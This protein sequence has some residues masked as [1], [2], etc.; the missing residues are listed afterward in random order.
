[1]MQQEEQQEDQQENELSVA[2]IND[3]LRDAEQRLKASAA[4]QVVAQDKPKNSLL[5]KSTSL[6]L[7]SSPVTSYIKGTAQGTQIDSSRLVS[8]DERK[9]AN[10]V[11]KVEDPVLVK[12]RHEN[13]KK[14]SAGP[15]WF[16]MPRTDVTPELKRDMQLLKMRSVLDPKRFYKKD[17]KK[18]D[19]PEFSQV[20]TIIEGPTEFRSARLTNKERKRTLVEEV[21]AGE[22]TTRRFKSKYNEIQKAKTSGRKDH[23]K[24]IKA[25]RRS[26]K[27]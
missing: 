17:T 4:T 12:S 26:K 7:G 19:I 11:R 10:T 2:Q 3:L 5:T 25:M 21:L 18:S 9:L 23:Y 15:M 1:M 20:G 16:N 24:K 27:T 14:A 13:E 8:A 6:S 22:K